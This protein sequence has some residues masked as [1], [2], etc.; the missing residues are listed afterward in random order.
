MRVIF[1][2]L[3]LL[4][5]L[6]VTAQ[7]TG[8]GDVV[9]NRCW[10]GAKR[11]SSKTLIDNAGKESVTDLK[12]R[13]INNGLFAG[14]NVRTCLRSE[15][16][17]YKKSLLFV[18]GIQVPLGFY[19]YLTPKNLFIIDSLNSTDGMA[20][21][22]P[23]A[24]DGA[25]RVFT[26]TKWML[27]VDGFL[28]EIDT[29]QKIPA[30]DILS[31][32]I[33]LASKATTIISCRRPRNILLITTHASQKKVMTVRDWQGG[34]L[35]PGATVSIFSKDKPDTAFL[36]ADDKGAVVL[37]PLQQHTAYTLQVSSVGY[38]SYSMNFI[39]GRDKIPGTVMLERD[40]KNCKP[41]TLTSIVSYR[42]ITCGGM[43]KITRDKTLAETKGVFTNSLHFYPNPVQK[44]GR[45]T[46]G[47]NGLSANPAEYRLFSL[48][49]MLMTRQPVSLKTA[50]GTIQVPIDSRWSA[51]TY[52]LQLV[53]E[54]GSVLASEKIILQ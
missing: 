19:S 35:L 27:V 20:L 30:S 14:K 2:F 41:V 8:S 38:K 53:C 48:G 10:G 24:K 33:L 32:D 5:N 6:I 50:N 17:N 25:I 42:K 45:L 12:L 31:I 44:G 11:D 26:K 7:A 4:F 36:V 3:F 40:I 16:N 9:V 52:F 23:E 47:W 15:A 51:G 34:D 46:F 29:V 13:P 54:N 28:S 39:P 21:Y 49:G 22:G 37:P 18:D 1:T 43:V